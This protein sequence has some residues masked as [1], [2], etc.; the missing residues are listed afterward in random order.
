[1]ISRNLVV[2]IGTVIIKDTEHVPMMEK[3]EESA[4]AYL[5]FLKEKR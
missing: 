1:M 4:K 5:S 3:P 2:L